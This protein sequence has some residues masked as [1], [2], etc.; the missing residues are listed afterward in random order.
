MNVSDATGGLKF[1]HQPVQSG[2]KPAQKHALQ[3][4]VLNA[5]LKK[6]TDTYIQAYPTTQT[7]CTEL[8]VILIAYQIRRRKE[9]FEKS[10]QST[11]PQ[12][13]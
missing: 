3:M 1:C 8:Q 7:R 4:R 10:E 5:M 6:N 11:S 13:A 9:K 2:C 12:T